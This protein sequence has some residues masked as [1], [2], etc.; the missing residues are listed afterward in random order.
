[1]ERGKARS[2]GKEYG[3]YRRHYSEPDFW[4][5]VGGMPRNAGRA[6]VEKAVTL[7]VILTDSET[8]MWARALVVGALGYFICP[9]DAIPDVI[10]V[11]GYADDVAVMALVLT[12]L[13]RFVT[14]AMRGRVQRL[15]PEGMRTKPINERRIRRDEQI[16]H[17]GSGA[18]GESRRCDR[19]DR[20]GVEAVAERRGR[21]H[22]SSR[23]SR[24]GRVRP[25]RE[26]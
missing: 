11:V 4:Q 25:H 16:E 24:R 7:Y 1:M 20:H 9:I 26:E 10:P 2:E 22:L 6:V 8:P 21:H 12:Q 14:P 18:G 19:Q 3:E 5:K 15:L 13:D 17:E 23:A